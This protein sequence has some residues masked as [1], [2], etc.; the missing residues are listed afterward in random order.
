MRDPITR[1][2]RHYSVSCSGCH[3]WTGSR[4][5]KGYGRFKDG[6]NRCVL[7]HRFIYEYLNGPIPH[8]LYVLHKCDNRCCVNPQH[9]YLGDQFDNMRDMITRGRSNKA[10]G[11]THPHA[12]INESIARRIK[13]LISEDIPTTHI[14]KLYHVS[15]YLI[16]DI[17][18]G[19]TWAHVSV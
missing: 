13:E 14:A 11:S 7:A 2:K 18:R 5:A 9:L 10:K 1:F 16:N 12:K 8:N 17:K 3:E 19:R 4:N 6:N 15:V